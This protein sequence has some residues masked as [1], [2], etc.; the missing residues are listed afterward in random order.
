[1]SSADQLP[2]V[3][4][5]RRLSFLATF[6][7]V[8][9]AAAAVTFAL[10]EVYSAETFVL[11]SA[12]RLPTND[13]EATQSN[14]V[15]TKT[16]A[17]LLQTRNVADAVAASLPYR[18]SGK[19]VQ[20]AV[21]IAPV[22]GTQLIR[23]G[24]EGSTGARAQTLANIYARTFVGQ[25]ARLGAPSLRTG[26]V[27]LAQPAPR[28]GDPS[29]PKP[30]L[31]LLVGALL[32]A[33][34]GAGVALLRQRLDQR[35]EIEPSTTELL[36][37]PILARVP[38]V[39]RIAKQVSRTDKG[40][41]GSPTSDAFRL[42]LVNLSFAN[43]GRQPRS[44]AVLSAGAGEGKSITAVSIARAALEAGVDAVLVDADLRRPSTA[45]LLGS[46]RPVEGAGLSSLLVRRQSRPDEDLAVEPLGL[47]PNVIPSGPLPPNPAAL[48]GAGG[49]GSLNERLQEAF[50]LVVYDTPPVSVGA[51]ASIVAAQCEAAVLVVNASKTRCDALLRTVDQLRRVN[52]NILGIV[53]NRSG[54]EIT[55]YKDYGGWVGEPREQASEG[56]GQGRRHQRRA[57]T[58]Q[59]T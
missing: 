44:L 11:V 43:H 51:D 3:L 53:V 47:L 42:L 45:T 58:T 28:P 35:L 32:A 14:Q 13:F 56:R 46:L 50:E 49:L 6:A 5:R 2:R 12:T 15:L 29:R 57:R 36:G 21:D 24:A 39:R 17:E 1:M 16:Y 18:S 8:L 41:G 38:E 33:F 55:Q 22:S 59:P 34:A 20:G 9:G 25:S 30:K 26:Q 27:T 10:P 31:Y 19:D 7:L 40:Y 48:L 4:W 23:I 54:A 52:V 37:L